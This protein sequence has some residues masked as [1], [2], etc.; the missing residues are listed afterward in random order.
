MGFNSGTCGDARPAQWTRDAEYSPSVLLETDM[1][2]WSIPHTT[3][4]CD[5]KFSVHHGLALAFIP[6]DHQLIQVA[7]GQILVKPNFIC[8]KAMRELVSTFH[9]AASHVEIDISNHSSTGP[10]F[11]DKKQTFSCATLFMKSCHHVAHLKTL[12]LFRWWQ[13]CATL[14]TRVLYA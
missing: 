2:V 1:A 14:W 4:S 12:L 3:S 10:R 5:R 8:I 7:R 6:L 11:D 13:Y 9:L